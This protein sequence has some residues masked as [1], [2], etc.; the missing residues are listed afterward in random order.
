MLILAALA[1]YIY[2]L[3]DHNSDQL[4]MRFLHLRFNLTLRKSKGS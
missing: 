3:N 1:Q 4:S 2:L